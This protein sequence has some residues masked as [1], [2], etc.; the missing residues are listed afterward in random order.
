VALFEQRLRGALYA[1]HIAGVIRRQDNAVDKLTTAQA[2]LSR[3]E[4]H[5][6]HI[7]GVGPEAC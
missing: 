5:V 4:W 7:I 1:V 2:L 6:D 3:A